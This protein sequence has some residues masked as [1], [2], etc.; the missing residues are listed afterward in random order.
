MTFNHPLYQKLEEYDFYLASTSPRRLEILLDNLKVQN[1]KVVPSEFEENLLK[2]ETSPS[3]YVERTSK[4]KGEAVL[5]RLQNEGD[6]DKFIVLSSDTIIACNNKVFE[7][8]ITK[9]VQL[10]F[11]HYYRLNPHLQVITSV[12]V[13]KYEAG[14]V[15]YR[16]GLEITDL[17]FNEGLSDEFLQYYVDSEEGLNVAGGFKYQCLG[18]LLF[19][20][21]EGDYFNVVGLPVSK[22]FQVLEDALK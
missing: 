8:P 16:H 3:V 19:K 9:D 14:S 12:N 20:R 11:F 4:K 6:S 5:K 18:S 21:L 22:T 7:K 17:Y 2:A 10:S 1:I 15:I 13:I